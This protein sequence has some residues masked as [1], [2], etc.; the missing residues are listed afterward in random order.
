MAG[1]AASTGYQIEKAGVEV[2]IE[3]LPHCLGDASQINRVFTNLL[4]NAL[5]FLP[6]AV[7]KGMT[8]IGLGV[9][10]A[11]YRDALKTNRSASRSTES[12]G[13]Q[14]MRKPYFHSSSCSQPG[15]EPP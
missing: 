3:P 15:A 13:F 8:F 4:T 12:P 9:D 2:D 1:V 7:A 10:T 11:L 14:S 6:E 5:K